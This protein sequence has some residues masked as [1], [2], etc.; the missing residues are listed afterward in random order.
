MPRFAIMSGLDVFNVINTNEEIEAAM[1]WTAA[2]RSGVQFVN[3]HGFD[4]VGIGHRYLDNKFYEPDD[5]NLENPV[6]FNESQPYDEIDFFRIGGVMENTVIGH[7]T[8]ASDS[9]PA[10]EEFLAAKYGF[11]SDPYVIEIHQDQIGLMWTWDGEKFI[12]PLEDGVS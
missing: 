4:S 12:P 5:E 3:L 1:K 9:F 6:D 11:I 10:I 8:Y 2:L 7:I